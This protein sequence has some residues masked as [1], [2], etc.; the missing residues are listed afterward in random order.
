MHG[1]PNRLKAIVLW[2]GLAAVLA[3]S[4]KEAPLAPPVNCP[5][6]LRL[7]VTPTSKVASIGETFTP[8]ATTLGC[9]GTQVL[10][11]QYRWQS[12]QP[13]VV[14][15]DSLTGRITAIAAGDANVSVTG[16]ERVATARLSVTV[17]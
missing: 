12:S 11:N 13:A 9:L 2:A 15:V 14:E 8:Q 4:E 1:I 10:T 5:A 16:V 7:T 17:R 3:C 6:D